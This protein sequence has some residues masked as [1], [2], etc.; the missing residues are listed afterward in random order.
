MN[1]TPARWELAAEL[2]EVRSRGR[3][4]LGLL[5]AWLKAGSVKLAR[6]ALARWLD[7]EGRARGEDAS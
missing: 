3:W 1:T 2:H 4:R 7:E 5:D 6:K